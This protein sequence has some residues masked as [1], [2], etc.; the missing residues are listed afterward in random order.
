MDTFAWTARLFIVDLKL[1]LKKKLL[2]NKLL[3]KRKTYLVTN[4]Q[5]AKKTEKKLL[6]SGI[7]WLCNEC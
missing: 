3:N 5:N 7:P 2:L 6:L 4:K 1:M